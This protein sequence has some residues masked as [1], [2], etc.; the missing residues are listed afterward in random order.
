MDFLLYGY[1]LFELCVEI[2]RRIWYNDYTTQ[3]C[4]NEKD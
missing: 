4:K 1:K 2:F 3:G